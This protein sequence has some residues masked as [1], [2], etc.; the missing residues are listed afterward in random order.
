MANEFYLWGMNIIVTGAS[1]GIGLA[2]AQWLASQGHTVLGIARS[3]PSEKL[4]FEFLTFDL[5]A[6]DIPS[7]VNEKIKPL[8]SEVHALVNNAGTLVNKPFEKITMDD[9]R[10]TYQVNVFSVFQ[11]T[12][13]L[14]PMMKSEAHIVNI[15]SMGGIGGTEK[16]AGLSAY[17]SSKG[18]LSIFTECLAVEL[19]DRG[20]SVNALA[21]GAVQTQML[22][23][24]FPDYKAPITAKE[25]GKFVGEF[26]VVGG[27]ETGR[28]IPVSLS[29]P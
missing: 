3:V 15:S 20:I 12:Q 1:R 23:L 10:M 21:L 29:T 7:F 13:C 2:T 9:L 27:K 17:S 19:K 8:F 24:A 14:L 22:E 5:S 16:F 11:L 25:M 26:V 18:A 4:S 28:V 6:G